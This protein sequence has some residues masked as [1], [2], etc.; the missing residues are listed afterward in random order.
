MDM[1]DLVG[2]Q[3]QADVYCLPCVGRIYPQVISDEYLDA[4]DNFIRC[5]DARVG[6]ERMKEARS[7][8]AHD[9][10]GNPVHPIYRDGP[11]YHRRVYCGTPTCDTEL[12]VD[13]LRRPCP[14]CQLLV[15]PDDLDFHFEEREG[16]GNPDHWTVWSR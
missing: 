13:V 15:A 10:E 1:K 4:Y 12:S 16:C 2:F 11:S 3:Y 9:K 5:Y 6:A 7:R 8:I 14:E